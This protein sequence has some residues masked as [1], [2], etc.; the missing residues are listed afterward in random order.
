MPLK[1]EFIDAR[2]TAFAIRKP[3]RCYEKCRN[4]RTDGRCPT[5]L[6]TVHSVA[7]IST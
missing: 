6:T 4:V 3:R 5:V 2:L 1:S 7:A